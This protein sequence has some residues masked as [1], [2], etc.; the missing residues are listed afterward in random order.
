M[1]DNT[2][3]MSGTDQAGSPK[4]EQASQ[5]TGENQTGLPESSA[6]QVQAGSSGQR[7]T[8]GRMPL[9]RR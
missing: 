4:S 6:Q 3:P 5:P 1:V 7:A 8:P 2:I 9:F